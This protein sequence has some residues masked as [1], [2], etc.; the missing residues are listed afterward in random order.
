V[1]N[2]MQTSSI[3]SRRGCRFGERTRSTSRSNRE[4]GDN[5]YASLYA[6]DWC[7]ATTVHSI[8]KLLKTLALA[9]KSLLRDHV[10]VPGRQM[11]GA[12]RL[13]PMGNRR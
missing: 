9:R 12:S 10:S 6:S 7:P 5:L 8:E 3:A 2:Y 4:N 13:A 11:V 1:L